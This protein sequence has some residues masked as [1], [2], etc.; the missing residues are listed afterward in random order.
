MILNKNTV[1]LCTLIYLLDHL[2][3]YGPSSPNAYLHKFTLQV[4]CTGYKLTVTQYITV[5]LI[6]E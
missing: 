4:I 2:T 5:W 6:V 3:K 1:S